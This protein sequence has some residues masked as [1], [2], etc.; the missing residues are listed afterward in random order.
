MTTTFN[1]LP[2]ELQEKIYFMK[3]Q[4]E[5]EDLCKEINYIPNRKKL[6]D[7]Y[8]NCIVGMFAYNNPKWNY[9]NLIAKNV[10]DDRYEFYEDYMRIKFFQYYFFRKVKNTNLINIRNMQVELP[11]ESNKLDIS[12]PFR[13]GFHFPFIYRENKLVYFLTSCVST[14]KELKEMCRI[15]N[16]KV[17]GNKRELIQRLIKLP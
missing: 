14:L 16:L 9:D 12:F 4:L 3:H 11:G 10:V 6:N 8:L 13:N 15:N 5:M 2:C 17:S 7:K 1:H